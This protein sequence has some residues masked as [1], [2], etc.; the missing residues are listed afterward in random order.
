MARVLGLLGIEYLMGCL[1]LQ[2]SFCSI[3][4]E[5]CSII[6][7]NGRNVGSINSSKLGL[8]GFEAYSSRTFD[9]QH[10]IR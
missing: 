10:K 1:S 2:E 4:A 7:E 8:P 5:I 3:K 9:N 6:S